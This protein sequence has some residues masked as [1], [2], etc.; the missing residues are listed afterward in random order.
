MNTK[1]EMQRFWNILPGNFG[2]KADPTDLTRF[3]KLRR[4]ERSAAEHPVHPYGLDIGRIS[5]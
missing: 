3:E 5:L 4:R 1:L 2:Q